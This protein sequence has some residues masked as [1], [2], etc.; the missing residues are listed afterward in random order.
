MRETEKFAGRERPAWPLSELGMSDIG[1]NG[2]LALVFMMS[3]SS[4][5]YTQND[6][7]NLF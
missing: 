3:V 7:V 6:K 4:G 2:I 5:S 1:R